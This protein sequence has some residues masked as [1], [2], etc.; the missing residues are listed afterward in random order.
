LS[1]IGN[2]IGRQP[3]VPVL[4]NFGNKTG[5]NNKTPSLPEGV[6]VCELFL[7]F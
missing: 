2:L 4:S 1:Q 5:R 6:F 3:P 7:V